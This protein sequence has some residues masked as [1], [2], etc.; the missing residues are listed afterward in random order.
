MTVH[1]KHSKA[2]LE[3]LIATYRRALE[4]NANT[5]ESLNSIL[6]QGTRNP[7]TRPLAISFFN[8]HFALHKEERAVSLSDLTDVVHETKANTKRGLPLLK[9]ASFG[10]ERTP[11]RSLRHNSNILS[12][13]GIE[14]DYDGEVYSPEWAEERL[15]VADIAAGRST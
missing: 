4:R 15:R 13:N 8:N 3:E 11:K 5:I 1:Y 9:L 10:D 2:C 14:G 12:I 7:L 6:V